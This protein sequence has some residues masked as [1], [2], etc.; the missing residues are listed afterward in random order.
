MDAI[1]KHIEIFEAYSSDKLDS[2][3]KLKFEEK[4][5][6]DKEF[7]SAFS[8]YLRIEEGIRLHFKNEFKTKLSEKDSELDLELEKLNVKKQ[9]KNFRIIILPIIAV[10]ASISLLFYF[11]NKQ[12][13]VLEMFPEDFGLPVKMGAQ[14]S[15]KNNIDAPMNA[16]KLGEFQ[17]AENL[18]SKIESD[19]SVYYSGICQYKLKDYNSAISNF[20]KIE[21]TSKYY[22]ESQYR[23][24]ILY[25]HQKK[26]SKAN[27]ILKHLLRTEAF[28]YRTEAQQLIDRID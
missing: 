4:L 6:S 28:K 22:L 7:E 20:N 15:V 27:E 16:Y 24:A 21:K 18:F 23:L 2:L 26:E 3:E 19:T 25:I 10:A 5:T 9:K 17:K 1:T 8:E 14:Q 12:S 11:T 13:D